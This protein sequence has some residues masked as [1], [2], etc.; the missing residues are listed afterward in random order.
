[1]LGAGIFINTVLLA[2]R[3]HLFSGALYLLNAILMLPLILSMVTLMKLHPRGGFYAFGSQEIS[4]FAGFV[5][6]WSYFVGKLASGTLMIHTAF[7]LLQT[8]IPT[9]KAF[10]TTT[11]HFVTLIFF[12]LL[13]LL[14]M[15]IGMLVQ[16]TSFILKLIPIVFVVAVG[17]LFGWS[18]TVS[19]PTDILPILSSI[20]L[21]LFTALGFEATLSLSSHIHNPEKNGP[22]A[23]L[24]AF[25]VVTI[26]CFLFQTSFYLLLGNRFDTFTNYLSMFPALLQT[27]CSNRSYTIP[28]AQI[29]HVAIASSAL[30]GAYSILFSTHWNLYAIAQHNHTFFN[31]L[32]TR[33]NRYGMPTI[34]IMLQALLCSICVLSTHGSQLPLQ[35]TA[36]FGCIIAY[37][38]TVY[39][40]I[41][42]QKKQEALTKKW[43]GWLALGNCSLFIISSC[44][45][46]F[47]TTLNSFYLFSSIL[48]GGI[49][50][51]WIKKLREK[52]HK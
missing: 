21:V 48:L 17:A 19:M 37:T 45:S 41:C 40:L 27:I 22:R 49:A 12:T 14:H 51:F 29:F 38:I 50:M 28:L 10:N 20:P 42:A 5:S 1:M 7:L 52:P 11:L 16:G 6:A 26:A 13:N 23:I 30:G 34:S 43:I 32:I 3:T 31:T 46:L 8:I 9:L 18:E 2:Q 33:K 44:Y 15:K 24:I 4:P 35:L 25:A 47:S 36:S 39:A